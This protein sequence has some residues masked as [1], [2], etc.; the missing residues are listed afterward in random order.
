MRYFKINEGQLYG[1]LRDQINMMILENAGVDNWPGWEFAW[2]DFIEEEPED[3]IK[4]YREENNLDADEDF[5]IDN[6][7][8][9]KVSKY[10]NALEEIKGEKENE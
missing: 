5:D 10:I 2:D 3:L 7:I 1:L 4:S 9:W 8:S 6:Y